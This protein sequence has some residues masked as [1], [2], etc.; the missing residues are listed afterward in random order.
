MGFRTSRPSSR[1]GE[2]AFEFAHKGEHWPPDCAYSSLVSTLARPP[3]WP[4]ILYALQL[5]QSGPE[6]GEAAAEL[7]EPP[8][9]EPVAAALIVNWMGCADGLVRR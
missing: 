1:V 6:A 4:L 8:D 7:D 5:S 2:W 3:R 9:P